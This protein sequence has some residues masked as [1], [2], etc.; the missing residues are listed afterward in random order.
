MVKKY[1]NQRGKIVSVNIDYLP[2][3]I[4]KTLKEWVPAPKPDV[5]INKQPIK[6]TRKP[7]Q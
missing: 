4:A 2:E 3:S 6:R 5:L 7:K 1:I